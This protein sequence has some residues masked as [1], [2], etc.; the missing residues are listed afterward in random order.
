MI[1]SHL[2]RILAILGFIFGVGRVVMGYSIASGHSGPYAD[3]LARYAP[4]YTSSGQLIDAGLYTIMAAVLV[5]T[6]AEI[7]FSIRKK[8]VEKPAEPSQ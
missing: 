2:A 5:G 6:L 3:A 8:A 7:S 4:G 1:F